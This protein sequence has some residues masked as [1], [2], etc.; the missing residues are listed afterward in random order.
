MTENPTETLL[1]EI[2]LFLERTGTTPTTFG[3]VAM[4]DPNFVRNLRAGR[5]PRFSTARR[6]LEFIRSQEATAA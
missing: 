4:G 1:S 2:D 6:A 3:K 5:E